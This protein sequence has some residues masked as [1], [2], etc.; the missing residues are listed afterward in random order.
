MLAHTEV[1][2]CSEDVMGRVRQFF[3][4]PHSRDPG[5][6]QVMGDAGMG[7]DL[8]PTLKVSVNS[9]CGCLLGHGRRRNRGKP[10]QQ[11]PGS[12]SSGESPDGMHQTGHDD[13]SSHTRIFNG[14]S[15]AMLGAAN[16]NGAYRAIACYRSYAQL[17]GLDVHCCKI[18]ITLIELCRGM[19]SAM[20]WFRQLTH[21]NYH[22][23][24]KFDFKVLSLSI[25]F[26]ALNRAFLKAGER[27]GAA[28]RR[29]CRSVC[30]SLQ[31][32]GYAFLRGLF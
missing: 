30:V 12:K 31:G 11:S 7:V 16:I 21:P 19:M 27:L 28:W 10:E 29:P 20:A 8:I 15:M 22:H 1:P 32:P 2:V 26:V 14:R 6:I 5:H 4:K 25:S 9:G 24:A 17:C 23:M 13:S 18:P 3:A